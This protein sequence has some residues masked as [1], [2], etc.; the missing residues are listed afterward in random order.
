MTD[1]ETLL[2]EVER[3]ADA[4]GLAPATVVSRALSDG[5]GYRRLKDGGRL[6]PET[7]AKLRRFMD[8]FQHTQPG[9]VA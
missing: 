7:E 4:V 1:Q 2:N 9:K 3:F 6:W 8:E 5:K